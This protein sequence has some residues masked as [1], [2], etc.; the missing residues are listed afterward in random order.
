MTP[1]VKVATAMVNVILP[2]AV[3]LI[4]TAQV[5]TGASSLFC[6]SVALAV[7]SSSDVVD[8]P[9]DV[10][11]ATVAKPDDKTAVVTLIHPPVIIE[12]MGMRV[13]IAGV[14]AAIAPPFTAKS[15]LA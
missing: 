14:I 12:L 4:G 13:L 2:A 6:V 10:P 5:G 15:Y 3:S 8:D 1:A 11:M 9:A 7:A